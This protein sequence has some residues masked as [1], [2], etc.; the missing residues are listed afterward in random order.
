MIEAKEVV[1]GCDVVS[2][3]ADVEDG[4]LLDGGVPGGVW[5]EQA[6]AQGDGRV[7]DE[8]FLAI[9]AGCV[10]EKDGAVSMINSLDVDAIDD[11]DGVDDNLLL[12]F[13]VLSWPSKQITFF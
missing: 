5:D 1:L 9:L 4:D 3:E 11:T 2:V 13:S 7:G 6:R 12:F 8:S 10:V